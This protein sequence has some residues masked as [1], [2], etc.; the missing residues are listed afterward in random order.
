MAN[1]TVKH[2][3]VVTN[4]AS[5]I[6]GSNIA[7]GES[8]TFA[9]GLSGSLQKTSSGISYLIAG[10]N[11]TITSGSNGQLTIASSG[12][13]SSDSFWYSDSAGIAKTTGS[14]EATGSGLIKQGLFVSGAGIFAGGLSGSLQKTS[15]GLSY[16]VAGNNVTITSGSNGQITITAATTGSV[17]SSFPLL[18]VVDSRFGG[19]P[20][21]NA[22]SNVPEAILAANA[23]TKPA[24]IQVYDG[25][26]A[27]GGTTLAISGGVTIAGMG[28]DPRSVTLQGTLNWASGDLGGIANLMV[29]AQPSDT[30]PCV[31]L[32]SPAFSTGFAIN[33]A[34]LYHATTAGDIPALFISSAVGSNTQILLTNV[35]VQA[36]SGAAVDQNQGSVRSFGGNYI[37]NLANSKRSYTLGGGSLQSNSDQ[38]TGVIRLSGSSRTLIDPFI[39]ASAA[40]S[41]A[42]TLEGSAGLTLSRPTIKNGSNEYWISTTLPVECALTNLSVASS[43][44]T[45][46]AHPSI[47][48]SANN[49]NPY[50]PSRVRVA[51]VTGVGVFPALV[52]YV[53]HAPTADFEALTLP[54]QGFVVGG[55]VL[56]VKN[57]A[58]Y[59]SRLTQG[60]STT[61]NGGSTYDLRLGER[62]TLVYDSAT[63]D[64]NVISTRL[65]FG[66]DLDYGSTVGTQTVTGLQTRD[67]SAVAPTVGQFIG[68]GTGSVW[69]PTNQTP[70]KYI[71]DVTLPASPNTPAGYFQSL[72]TALAHAN[73]SASVTQSAVISVYPGQYTTADDRFSVSNYVDIQGMASQPSAVELLKPIRFA[74]GSVSASLNNI[75]LNSGANEDII[76]V[77]HISASL[78][79]RNCIARQTNSGNS[80][81]IV[82]VD[83]NGHGSTLSFTDC[84]LYAVDYS[85]VRTDNIATINFIRGTVEC[86]R[87]DTAK[88]AVNVATTTGTVTVTSQDTIFYGAVQQTGASTIVL[89]LLRGEID[90]TGNASVPIEFGGA[91]AAISAASYLRDIVIKNGSATETIGAGAGGI[92]TTIGNNGLIFPA[93][94]NIGDFV[95][96]LYAADVSPGAIATGGGNVVIS[97]YERTVYSNNAGTL[98]LPS[99]V[100]VPH[101]TIIKVMRETA[102]G[103]QTVGVASGDYLDSTLNGTNTQAGG[104]QIEYVA[105]RVGLANATWVSFL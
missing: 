10:S 89:K 76:T 4:S 72:T 79:F 63:S 83:S 18:Y 53:R 99:I 82:R 96:P 8:F 81:G 36:V 11:V 3:V 101:G 80:K 75:K 84:E 25:T 1:A 71:V 61:I 77:Y 54:A 46:H 97:Y 32:T 38:F 23:A 24:L 21:T 105:F 14:F 70:L 62:A 73:V 88:L 69:T 9:G 68:W 60:G 31:S 64:Y 98:T 102:A 27:L 104:A 65:E 2:P 56:Y 91:S 93:T 19:S 6:S 22:F 59:V 48:F 95:R 78:S 16:L 41:P 40:A 103:N 85:T 57:G 86:G 30:A 67:L 58:T 17:S 12:G 34:Y 90:L 15:A 49:T 33:N 45:H 44:N 39:D 7:P 51:D 92:S 100:L 26:Y 29:Y 87:A 28:A 47:N 55:T 5:F 94:G 20:P 42:I 37:V 35:T 66:G 13:A 74:S 50:E 52:N 43:T